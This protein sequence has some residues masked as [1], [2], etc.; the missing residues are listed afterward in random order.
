MF[1][2]PLSERKFQGGSSPLKQRI[3]YCFPMSGT[4]IKTA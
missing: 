2:A 1:G 4:P 3:F